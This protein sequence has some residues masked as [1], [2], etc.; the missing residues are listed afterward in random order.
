MPRNEKKLRHSVKRNSTFIAILCII[1]VAALAFGIVATVKSFENPAVIGV[2]K[3]NVE[4]PASAKRVAGNIYDLG[5]CHFKGHKNVH[6]YAIIHTT[7][8][9]GSPNPEENHISCCNPISQGARWKT[10]ENFAIDPTNSHMLSTQFVFNA[11]ELSMG[12]WDNKIAFGIFGNRLDASIVDGADS[13]APD[14]K[15]EILFGTLAQN[16]VIAVTFLWG[17]FGG[18]IA[19]RELLEA[20]IVFNEFF[21]W[22]NAST[23][24]GVMDLQNIATHEFGHYSGLGHPPLSASCSDT[25]MFGTSSLEETQKRTLETE[26]ILC[27][28]ELYGDSTCQPDEDEDPPFKFKNDATLNAA[29]SILVSAIMLMFF[30]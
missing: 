2:H 6:G 26:D 25:T 5:S 4:L 28:C 11:I 21:S 22:G 29:N 18:P 3:R 7:G 20:D 14:G 9:L 8:D 30:L 1:A 23:N 24:M 19:N 12:V 27:L 13:V 16:N 17:V 10:T 15:N